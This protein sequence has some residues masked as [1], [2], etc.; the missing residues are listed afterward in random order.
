MHII[1][2]FAAMAGAVTLLGCTASTNSS[3]VAPSGAI[4]HT[5]KCSQSAQACFQKATE[6]CKGPYAVL[7]SHSNAGG[8]LADVLPGPVTWYNMTYSCGRSDGIAHPTFPFR[9]QQFQSRAPS[10]T[11]CQ[12]F[13]NAVS[14]QSF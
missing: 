1:F 11:N 5:A 13:G 12:R 4:A 2:K 3:F 8:L 6:T 7:D 14:C 9:G 10:V